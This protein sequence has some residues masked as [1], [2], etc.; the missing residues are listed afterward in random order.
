MMSA[1]HFQQAPQSIA[2]SS[3]FW[4]FPFSAEEL[5]F[6]LLLF[7]S[8]IALFYESDFSTLTVFHLPLTNHFEF[9]VL[10]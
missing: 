8:S 6:R 5:I 7:P 2:F 3:S 9:A 1:P 10:F 4:D